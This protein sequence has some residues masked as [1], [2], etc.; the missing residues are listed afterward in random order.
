M[1]PENVDSR[2]LMP[3]KFFKIGDS[4]KLIPANFSRINE[5]QISEFLSDTVFFELGLLE[6][7]GYFVICLSKKVSIFTEIVLKTIN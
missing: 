4:R 7:I 3:T 5:M 6:T 2:K 1:T